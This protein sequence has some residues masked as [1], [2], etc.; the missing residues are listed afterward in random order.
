[1]SKRMLDSHKYTD[2]VP[3]SPISKEA[4]WEFDTVEYDVNSTPPPLE[5]IS[6][7]IPTTAPLN[8]SNL[9]RLTVCPRCRKPLVKAKSIEGGESTFFNE[10]PACGTLVNTFQPLPHQAEFLSHPSRYKMAAGGYGSGKSAVD[11]QYIIKHMFLIPKAR[12]CVYART[13]TAIESTFLKEFRQ[14]FPDSLFQSK[15]DTKHE[16]YFTNGAVLMMRS[17]DDPTKLKS[18][19][20]TLAV[21]IEASDLGEDGF[22]MLKS[23]IRN[24]AALI[25][26]VDANGKPIVDWDDKQKVYVPRYKYDARHILMETNPASNWVKKFLTDSKEVRY[27]GSSKNEGYKM[28]PKPHETQYT[29][30]I[31]TDANPYLPPSYIPELCEGK[32]AAW[33]AQ[34]VYGSFNFN[35]SLVYPN[36]GLC[37]VEP[38]ELPRRFDEQGRRRLFFSTSLDYGITDPTHILFFAVSLDTKK[39]YVFDEYRT[40]NSDVP[41]ITKEYRRTVKQNGT[42]LDGLYTLPTFD[43]RSYNKRESNLKTI[44]S[45]FE[46]QGLYFDPVFEGR[47]VRI[48]RLNTLINHGQIEIFSNCEYL[49]EEI[50]NL[51]FIKDKEGNPTKVPKDGKDH[52]ITALEFGAVRLPSNLQEFN[53][54]SYLPTGEKIVHDKHNIPTVTKKEKLYNPLEE[55]NHDR[56][57]RIGNNTSYLSFGVDLYSGLESR[58]SDESSEGGLLQDGLSELQAYV[59]RYHRKF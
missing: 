42:D 57:N 35:D 2:I 26:E 50:L 51:Q 7:N 59:P 43:G 47:E 16:Y 44:G 8:I 58:E 22:T 21:I 56:N 18:M 10:C 12:V 3:P 9:S 38:H 13:Y 14:I 19:N 27:F 54:S 28:N 34:F 37:I 17:A 23:R 15:N 31:P 46:E 55:D 6:I 36:A 11:I 53:L 5:D 25:P 45:E 48:V 49:I 29:Q 33:V 24:T 52:G 20:L 30:V 40:S 32:S 41:T 1:M 39:L 4:E